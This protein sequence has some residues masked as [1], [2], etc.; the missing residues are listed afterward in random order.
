MYLATLVAGIEPP[1]LTNSHGLG[2]LGS[3]GKILDPPG[4]CDVP[5]NEKAR[6]GAGWICIQASCACLRAGVVDP[7]VEKLSRYRQSKSARERGQNA[8][9][10]FHRWAHR[11]GKAFRVPISTLKVPIRCRRRSCEKRVVYDKKVDYP[12]IFLSDWFETVMAECPRF[13]LGGF[14]LDS[15]QHEWSAMFYNFWQYY[16]GVNPLHPVHKK[17]A[18]QKQRSIPVAL[19]GDEGRGLSKVPL[20]V[21]SFQCIIPSSGWNKLNTTQYL[22]LHN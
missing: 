19:H 18:L 4:R 20:L 10:D 1:T 2:S 7:D 13:F 8:A 3:L 12:V 9:R 6:Q 17:T 11:E 5:T 15:Q 14:D 22:V 16:E 21:W